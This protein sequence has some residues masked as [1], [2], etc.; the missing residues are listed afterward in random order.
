L[1]LVGFASTKETAV[2]E[3]NNT[4]SKLDNAPNFQNIL[5]RGLSITLAGH[6]SHSSH[7][8]HGSHRSSSGSSAVPR[9]TP[10]A[11]P[12]KP[13]TPPRTNRNL[14]S[15]PPASVLPN[16]PS[17]K[18]PKVRGNSAQFKRIVTRVQMLLFALGYYT[19]KLDGIAG[20]DT[21]AAVAKYQQQYGLNVNGQINE[22]LIKG[23]NIPID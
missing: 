3:P 20:T 10:K 15:N 7:G 4:V 21:R 22:Q 19:G 6:R 18:L 8:S 23:M 14:N 1:A 17:T 11:S 9:Y 2:L 16:V 5:D 13:W 12:S